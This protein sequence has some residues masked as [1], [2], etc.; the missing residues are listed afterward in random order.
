MADRSGDFGSGFLK[1]CSRDN[2][3]A[4]QLDFCQNCVPDHLF[5]SVVPCNWMLALYLGASLVQRDHGY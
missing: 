2:N 4:M 1:V 3:R 5:C